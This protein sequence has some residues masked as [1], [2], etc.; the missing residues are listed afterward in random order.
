MKLHRK[1]LILFAAMSLGGMLYL[2]WFALEFLYKTVNTYFKNI[3]TTIGSTLVLL[4]IVSVIIAR[5]LLRF[6]RIVDKAKRGEEVTKEEK[7]QALG[8][9]SRLNAVS[10]ITNIAGFLVGQIAVLILET[11]SGNLV[12]NV[13]RFA[14]T[15]LEAS[16]VGAICALFEMYTLNNWMAESRQLLRIQ[17]VGEFGGERKMTISG[18]ITL[19]SLVTLGFMG[20]NAFASPFALILGGAGDASPLMGSYLRS[21]VFAIAVTL[22][23]CFFLVR[24]IT[25][26]LKKRVSDISARI[27]DLGDEGD[28]SSRIY[29]SM[30]DDFGGLTSKLNGFLDQLSTLIAS[31]KEETRIVADTAAKLSASTE[32]S[33]MALALMKSSADRMVKEG[34]R[35]NQR[36]SE[37]HGGIQGIAE[38]AKNVEEQVLVQS[39]AVEESSASVNEM[40]ANIA[41]VAEMASKAEGLSSRL[42]ESSSGG[43]A[44]IKSA[45]DAIAEIQTASNEVKSIIQ[46]IQKISSQ[47]NLL[48]MNAAIEAAH[49][50]EAGRG[51]AVVANEV[52][53]LA[54]S[55]ARSAKNIQEHIKDMVS[56]INYGV[57]AISAA[58]KAFAEINSSVEQTSGLIDTISNAMD[59]QR[60]GATETLSSTNSVVDAIGMIRDLSSQQRE[61][62]EKMAA[63]MGSLLDS[64]KEIDLALRENSSNAESIDGA[65][66]NVG[67]CV[68]DTSEAIGRMK[69]QIEVFKLS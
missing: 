68:V 5:L 65:V 63:A 7:A 49:A 58:G 2:R 37:T 9:Y 23:P 19:L 26:E 16:F 24:I 15:V 14:F 53:V 62:A 52:G 4:A 18:R 41:S 50:G 51:F 43:E 61:Y 33:K 44:S 46:E 10:I 40:A 6:E 11:V 66:R 3:A 17:D 42:R 36:I 54:A 38:N 69:K 47:T 27:E 32:E 35:Q 8:A 12:P 39:A 64:A 45:I 30:N 48:S 29:I 20:L 31:L 13:P 55:S 1:Y 59:E 34:E 56:K 28:L 57:A 22:V 21:G 67:S 60:I 25:N